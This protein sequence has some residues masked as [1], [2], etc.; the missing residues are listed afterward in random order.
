ME[1]QI[2]ISRLKQ[3]DL[4]SLET[5]VNRYQSRAVHAAYLILYDRALSEDVVQSAFVGT[6]VRFFHIRR[7][8]SET[9]VL[10]WRSMNLF[11]QPNSLVASPVSSE[12]KMLS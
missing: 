2:A 11:R 4:N 12:I 8:H 1:D 6:R 10:Y 3:G 9:R 7:F 5:L